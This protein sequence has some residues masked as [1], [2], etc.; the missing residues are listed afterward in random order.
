MAVCAFHLLWHIPQLLIPRKCWVLQVCAYA[1]LKTACGTE[2]IWTE[3]L[4][5]P[6]LH[7]P[8]I[9]SKMAQ[10]GFPI[11]GYYLICAQY[12]QAYSKLFSEKEPQKS[13]LLCKTLSFGYLRW[14]YL[15]ISCAAAPPLRKGLHLVCSQK[16]CCTW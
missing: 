12:L 3:L 10:I 14:K 1:C 7:M 16:L 5:S 15:C 8:S 11:S 4:R 9:A 6:H 13:S 2:R